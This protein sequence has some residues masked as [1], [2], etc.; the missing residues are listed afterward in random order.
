MASREGYSPSGRIPQRARGRERREAVIDAACAI[1]REAGEEALTLH[2]AAQRARSSI[3]SM[4]HFFADRDQLL[5]SV[6]DRH[7]DAMMRVAA[8]SRKVPLEAWR[9]MTAA[10]VIAVLFHDPLVYF[11]AH[12]DALI[13]H[14]LQDTGPAEAFQGL[15]RRVMCARLGDAAGPAAAA[16]LY[17]VSTG[18]LMYLRPMRA[19][20]LPADQVDIEG[21]LVAYLERI[22]RG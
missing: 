1:L 6:A 18:T 15:L 12:P 19:T 10:Q 7:R 11:V 21:A 9:S 3:G 22:E 2:A 16:T 5:R 8:P 13:V 4:Y 17:A 20:L 14:H